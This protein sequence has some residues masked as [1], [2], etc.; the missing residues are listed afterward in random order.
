MKKKMLLVMILIALAV[1]VGLFF[2]FKRGGPLSTPDSNSPFTKGPA[3]PSETFINYNDPAGFS[4][5]YPDNLSITKNETE[6][7]NSYAD[8]Q[9][10]SKDVSGSINLKITDTKLKTLD[11]WLKES[12]V[13]SSS[14]VEKNLGNLKALEVKTADRLMLGALDQGVF[15]TVEVPLIEQDFWMKVYIK[16][17]SDFTFASPS[18]NTAQGGS[19]SSS[20]DVT[21]EAEEVVE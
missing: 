1:L 3:N 11:D 18:A 7:P 5:S 2:F 20:E 21:F 14:A 15:F 10:Y 17:L 6:D 19:D 12:K 9:L 16:L 4:F 13:A 8:L